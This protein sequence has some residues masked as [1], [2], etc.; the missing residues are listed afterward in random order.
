MRSF[1]SILSLTAI[2]MLNGCFHHE[3]E[4]TESAEEKEPSS[5]SD[6]KCGN[7][8]SCE[9]GIWGGGCS[10]NV[11][12]S[13]YCDA[14]F[15]A[16]GRTVDKFGTIYET[17]ND[18]DECADGN[19]CGDGSR[20][21]NTAGSYYCEGINE[22][23]ENHDICGSLNCSDTESSY[24]CECPSRN[25]FEFSSFM[26]LETFTEASAVDNM[27]YTLY[28]S[29][30]EIYDYSIDSSDPETIPEEPVLTGTAYF[31]KKHV[32]GMVSH[33]D[34]IF[35]ICTDGVY[36]VERITDGGLN[37]REEIFFPVN[38]ITAWAEDSGILVMAGYDAESDSRALFF[39]DITAADIPPYTLQ[40]NSTDTVDV[41]GYRYNNTVLLGYSDETTLSLNIK[42][43]SGESPENFSLK[44]EL[45]IEP[46][47]D[48]GWGGYSYEELSIKITED[49]A[50]LVRNGYM[51]ILKFTAD[52]NIEHVHFMNSSALSDWIIENNYIV[53]FSHNLSDQ[54]EVFY[55]NIT[56]P[57]NPQNFLTINF[58]FSVSEAL[59][60]NNV[61]FAREFD[62]TNGTTTRIMTDLEKDPIY[63]VLTE[64]G[65]TNYSSHAVSYS[66]GLT[67][68]NLCSDLLETYYVNPE[69]LENNGSLYIH[70]KNSIDIYSCDLEGSVAT[71]INAFAISEEFAEEE[72]R[73][74]LKTPAG[75]AVIYNGAG[76]GYYYL[77][78][79][80]IQT[81]GMLKNGITVG[82][83]TIKLTTAVTNAA[84]LGNTLYLVDS[85]NI[86]TFG[87][88]DNFDK[89]AVSIDIGSDVFAPTEKGI[90]VKK[91]NS[92]YY[93]DIIPG[94]EPLKLGTISDLEK[95]FAVN[96]YLIT[97][98]HSS[99]NVWVLSPEK[100]L[101][102]VENTVSLN[103][104][105]GITEA[106]VENGDILFS[107]IYG[108]I[109]KLSLPDCF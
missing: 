55:W 56:D 47:D 31:D 10:G 87:K 61:I 57:Y 18:I 36:L 42:N 17:C 78:E 49:K 81:E 28:L 12:L 95:I 51:D 70:N 98:S 90:Y 75:I 60:N 85:D 5:C 7:N 109:Y 3:K 23:I 59:K 69:I 40:L 33:G 77:G 92:I 8:S 108:D 68:I 35:M 15:E 27:H 1:L 88:L 25:I 63:A 91:G 84:T 13:C 82:E 89:T 107:T 74:L 50:F 53:E 72:N 83:G 73:M 62:K 11:Q 32:L 29:N 44:N 2:F 41:L 21:T 38:D 102:L 97:Q 46:L 65:F 96:G 80:R 105:P 48:D 58:D 99:I 71:E 76:F 24:K 54:H 14:G 104:I 86:I 45:E 26:S 101:V 16:I 52:R 100:S 43:M 4:K 20:C 67:E 79:N 103:E 66:S 94:K 37:V 9:D 34:S 39:L 30:N 19:I 6:V 22:C 93:Y 106:H 64:H